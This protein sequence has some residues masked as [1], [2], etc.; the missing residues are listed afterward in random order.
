MRKRPVLLLL[1]GVFTSLVLFLP[2][3]LSDSPPDSEFVY[4]RIRYHITPDAFRMREAPWH[5]DYPYGDEAL[6]TI[7]GEVSSVKTGATSYHI[8]D[9]DSPDLFRYPFAYFPSPDMWI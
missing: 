3:S 6:P 1:G 4:A 9:I 5:H 7:L 8:V 2:R